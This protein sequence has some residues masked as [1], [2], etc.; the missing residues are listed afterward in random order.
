MRAATIGL[1]VLLSTL[2]GAPPALAD[3]PVQAV[4]VRQDVAHTSAAEDPAVQPPFA[5]AWTHVFDGFVSQ[6]LIAGGRVFAV[7]YEPGVGARVAALDATTGSLLWE[8]VDTTW[9]IAG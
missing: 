9:L 1:L 2:A 3:A 6:P 5:R 7:H 8:S 4:S